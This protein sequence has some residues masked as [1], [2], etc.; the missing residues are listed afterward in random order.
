MA[1]VISRPARICNECIDICLEIMLDDILM[2]AVPPS[3]SVRIEATESVISTDFDL[4]ELI[5]NVKR[6]RQEQR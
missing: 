2:M 4:G 3:P 1:G 5:P 6:H